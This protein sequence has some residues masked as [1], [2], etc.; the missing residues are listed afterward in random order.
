VRDFR[1]AGNERPYL[2]HRYTTPRRGWRRLGASS[3]AEGPRGIAALGIAGSIPI[4]GHIQAAS[5]LDLLSPGMTVMNEPML[6]LHE[7]R[8]SASIAQRDRIGPREVTEPHLMLGSIVLVQ[9]ERVERL[10]QAVVE[11]RTTAR[12]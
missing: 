8:R 4:S 11:R 1:K 2:F 3:Y 7:G 9:G 6:V 5:I 12:A 10:D